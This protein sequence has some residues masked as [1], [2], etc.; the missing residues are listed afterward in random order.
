VRKVAV[1]TGY[2]DDEFIEV[3]GGVALGDRVVEVGQGALRDGSKIRDLEAERAADS[4]RG[5]P[6]GA[7]GD[8]T[9]SA[10][11]DH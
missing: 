7:A 8:G 4:S 9:L 1:T 6:S 11:D 2:A 3:L 5:D 10:S